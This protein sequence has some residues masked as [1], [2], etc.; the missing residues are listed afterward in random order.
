MLE[1]VFEKVSS[2]NILNY[3]FPGVVFIFLSKEIFSISFNSYGS[4]AD[5][6]IYYFIGMVL[7]RIGSIIVEP[8]LKFLKL[9]KFAPYNEYIEASKKDNKIEILMETGNMYRSLVAIF[10]VVVLMEVYVKLD[11]EMLRIIKE[12]K[13]LTI[14][15]F[16]FFFF[17][18]A[19]IKQVNYIKKRIDKNKK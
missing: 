8:S 6:M 16:L 4:L 9:V 10:L 12:E 13:G 7:S 14:G 1:K 17:I 11:I 18:L 3:I 5:F 2:Y 15:I 19:Y